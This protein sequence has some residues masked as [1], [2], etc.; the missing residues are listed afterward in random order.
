M[1]LPLDI[2]IA[3]ICTALHHFYVF[4]S[5][6]MTTNSI[7]SIIYAFNIPLLQHN[8]ARNVTDNSRISNFKLM[9]CSDIAN[10]TM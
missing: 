1:N 2:I 10:K 5:H 3:N 6:K 9:K 7:S 4:V 8:V